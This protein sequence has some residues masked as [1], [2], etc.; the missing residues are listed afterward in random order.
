MSS[1]DGEMIPNELGHFPPDWNSEQLSKL[2]G[3]IMDSDSHEFKDECIK[4]YSSNGLC[5]CCGLAVYTATTGGECNEFR[6]YC[7]DDE[8]CQWSSIP[9]LDC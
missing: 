1:H 5:S 9:L 3:E 8:S 2:I 7:P 4:D 6:Q